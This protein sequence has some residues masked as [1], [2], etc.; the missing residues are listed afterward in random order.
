M[1]NNVRK[2]CKRTKIDT[3][4]CHRLVVRNY[5]RFRQK[6]KQRQRASF[7]VKRDHDGRETRYL[8]QEIAKTILNDAWLARTPKPK[9]EI[10]RKPHK[11]TPSIP[12][13][14]RL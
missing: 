7:N 13:P 1:F 8:A 10:W 14:I 9:V 3:P 11:R 5:F 4:I 12:L 2:T 6:R